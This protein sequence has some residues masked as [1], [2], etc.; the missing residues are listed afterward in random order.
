M[1][2]WTD[3]PEARYLSNLQHPLIAR[4]YEKYNR[5]LGNRCGGGMTA[6]QRRDFDRAMLKK[7]GDQY[8]PPARTEWVLKGWEIL[9]QAVANNITKDG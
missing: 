7:Y 4:E 1:G 3:H 8:P 2:I 9:E 6:Q 5:E